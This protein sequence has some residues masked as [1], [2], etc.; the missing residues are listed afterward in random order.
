[1][2]AVASVS[3]PRRVPRLLAAA[4]ALVAA[5]SLAAGCQRD[6]RASVARIDAAFAA[7]DYARSASL[8]EAA[9]ERNGDDEQDRLV[10]WLE[11][12]RAR[13]AEGS[14]ERASGWYA[15]A[16]EEVRPYLDSKAEASVSE[17][18]VTTAVNQT[19]RTY[20]A[21]PP[22]R[23]M[24]CSLQAANFLGRHDLPNARIELNRAMD[25]QQDAV[26]RFADEVNEAQE[27]ANKEWSQKGWSSS[28][29]SSAVEKVRKEQAR[30]PATLG[31]AS[32]ANP[33]ASYLRAAFLIATSSEAGDRQNARADL[34]AV[35]E[36]MPGLAAAEADIALVDS[37]VSHGQAAVTWVF[38]L[39]GLAP[40]YREFRLDIPIPV[41]NVNYVS[42]AF[43]V[44]RR[45]GDFVGAVHSHSVA[46]ER[47][48]R[49]ADLDAM[50]EADFDARLPLIVTQEIISS[51]GKAAATWAASQAA[52]QHDSTTGAIVQIVGI[53]YQ[54]T[55]TAADLR[56]WSN[57]PKQVLLLRV[58]TPP[59]GRL[60]IVA[61]G[62]ARLCTLD[63]EP[64]APNI[65]VVTV[66][67][68]AARAPGV[69]L[70]RGGTVHGPRAPRAEPASEEFGPP[71][72]DAPASTV[73]S[74]GSTP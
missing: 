33:F 13:Q 35:Q 10:W 49:L 59:D 23:I 20:R 12:G 34:R 39:S 7:G 3:S 55:S 47:S 15:R 28:V 37:G 58:P 18:L 36:M 9:A 17:A 66:P 40:D 53:L 24:L 62:G 25:F 48:E 63:L 65:A 32:F 68:T 2:V 56:C 70:Y 6:L 42:A 72:P 67:S 19:L 22:E 69:I 16:I 41:G 52:Y 29:S 54:A 64:E 46:G 27:A 11:A 38:V 8:A 44:L 74:R 1:M 21:T 31:K 50:V 60:P 14:L 43:P 45:R 4:S 61:E 57:M 26:A 73:A 51:A 5:A 71:S 30:D